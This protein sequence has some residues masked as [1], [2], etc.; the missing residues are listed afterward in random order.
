MK[1]FAV[2][3]YSVPTG[4][5]FVAVEL[6]DLH[7]R[8]G[9]SVRRDQ[10]DGLGHFTG[11][12]LEL[13]KVRHR[14]ERRAVGPHVEMSREDAEVVQ[15]AML[16]K[17]TF[18]AQAFPLAK[19]VDLAGN[20]E[21]RSE[22][23]MLQEDD[24]RCLP[25]QFFQ[26]GFEPRERATRELVEI[27]AG[28]R[29]FVTQG[30]GGVMTTVPIQSDEDLKERIFS[31]VVEQIRH[32][33]GIY[34]VVEL[35]TIVLKPRWAAM[36]GIP[37]CS[38]GIVDDRR[39]SKDAA[40][41]ASEELITDRCDIFPGG[42]VQPLIVIANDGKV[43]HGEIVQH[44]SHRVVLRGHRRVRQITGDEHRLQI[45]RAIRGQLIDFRHCGT[46]AP[47]GVGAGIT[48]MN[49]R[50]KSEGVLISPA[51]INEREEQDDEPT[52]HRQ[53]ER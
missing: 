47:K 20:V 24:R 10:G 1:I 15:R 7:D 44:L 46:S 28:H 49:V 26:L 14:V 35:K 18:D 48:D 45:G 9:L 40:E 21:G 11:V 17:E 38:I 51:R 39:L 8:A 22:G 33:E 53:R 29:T 19:G 30:G 32:G 34:I 50:E 13:S 25:L 3:L 36:R 42:V 5:R 52:I 2:T 23:L 6:L 4:R 27:N 41:L 37:H 12:G 16:S 31:F 43:G